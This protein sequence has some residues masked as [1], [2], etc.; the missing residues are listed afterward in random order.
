VDKGKLIYE[1]KE[2]RGYVARAWDLPDSKGDAL[3][4]IT[5]GDSVVREFLF[6]AYKVWNIAA[7]LPDIVDSELAKDCSGYE[8]AASTGFGGSVAMVP[9]ESCGETV[10]VV[11]QAEP[12]MSE[13]TSG[14]SA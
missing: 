3:I 4:Q 11:Q 1:T 14:E 5:K 12:N 9:A 6:P 7:H 10:N 8:V 2:E 13:P